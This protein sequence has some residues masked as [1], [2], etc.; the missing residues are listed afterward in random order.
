MMGMLTPFDF[1][2]RAVRVVEDQAGL[3]WFVALDVCEAL[4]IGNSRM[5]VSRLDDDEKGV[6]TADTLGG[7][8]QLVTVNEAGL[9]SLTLTSRKPE[10]KRFKRWITHDVLPALRR[11]GR[12]A[13]PS[14]EPEPT[15]DMPLAPQH[16]ADV[17]VAASRSFAAM[18][19]TARLFGLGRR[20]AALNANAAAEKL[21]GVNL[22]ELLDAEDLLD[23]AH[24]GV[25]GN[26]ELERLQDWLD[27][28]SEAKPEA[29]ATALGLP[30]HQRSAQMR[31]AG[32]LKQAGW[33]K[34]RSLRDGGRT[35]V[36]VPGDGEPAT[37]EE[38]PHGMASGVHEFLQAWRAGRW[39]VVPALSTDVHAVYLGWCAERSH[40][41]LPIGA[42][43][44]QLRR[45]GADS[46]RKRWQAEGSLRGPHAVQWPAAMTF[47][48]TGVAEP[49]WLGES[50]TLFRNHQLEAR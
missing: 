17:V 5:A 24:A 8:Q 46:A 4:G 49:E 47:P 3:S 34:V 43:A 36:Y 38:P 28:R 31:V 25:P 14:A 50:I 9:Y 12:Y 13:M 15:P 6:S 35:T 22:A 23:D 26:P 40:R 30:P 20:R 33:V 32:L 18:V 7:P 29:A 41:P 44:V 39:P 45:L 42:F 1:E 16:R 19:R 37:E 10:A 27:G 2:G 11:T 48:P 21:T